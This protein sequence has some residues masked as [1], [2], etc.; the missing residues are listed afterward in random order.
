M[1]EI[2]P[3]NDIY[4]ML[5]SS[6]PTL[7]KAILSL[8]QSSGMTTTNLSTLTL[9]D[10]LNACEE[11]FD[12][13]EEKTFEILL[14]KD[15]WDIIPCWKLKNDKKITFNTPETTFHIFMYLK[16]KRQKDF[17][18][19]S[20]PLFKSGNNNFL[21]ANKIS[22][23]ITEFNKILN[24]EKGYFK[25][26]NL[27][28]TF[29]NIC[30]QHLNLEQNYKTDIINLFIKGNVK[31]YNQFNNNYSEIKQYYKRLIPFL[32]VRTFDFNK[33]F[34]IYSNQLKIKIMR[35]LKIIIS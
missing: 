1:A 29:E 2:I 31:Y 34:N 22:S 28:K 11:Y 35:L 17:D 33:Q 9:N 7:Y 5:C 12:K 26:K 18:D 14:N 10:F 4:V 23:Y 32:T 27:I 15:P 24:Y 3:I 19:L 16:E 25:S 13:N 8:I 30:K 21:K 20:N 6:K